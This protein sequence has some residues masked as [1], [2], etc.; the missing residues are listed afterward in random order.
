M[1]TSLFIDFMGDSPTVRVMDYLLT[2]RELDFCITDI[3]DNACIGR[4]TL[5]R[6]WDDLLRNNIIVP[7]RVIG[8]AKLFKLNEKNPKVQ[9]LVELDDMLIMDD[10]KKRSQKQKIKVTH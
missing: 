10:L 7:T 2:E 6:I 5:Y 1:E 9:K 8:K 3:A 4:S